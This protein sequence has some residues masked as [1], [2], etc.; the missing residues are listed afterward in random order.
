MEIKILMENV[1]THLVGYSHGAQKLHSDTTN[2]PH[3]V[4]R[5]HFTAIPMQLVK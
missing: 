1:F 2:G 5:P 3:A 4:R